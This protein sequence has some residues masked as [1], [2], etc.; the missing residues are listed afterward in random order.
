MEMQGRSNQEGAIKVVRI[1]HFMESRSLSLIS[2]CL[3]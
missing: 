3:Y 2:T 1:L